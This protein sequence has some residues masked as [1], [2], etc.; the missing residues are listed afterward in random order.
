MQGGG[1]I[2]AALDVAGAPITVEEC[3]CDADAG[4][5]TA[6]DDVVCLD[7]GSADISASVA[8]SP[9]VPSGYAVYYVLTDADN[10]LTVVNASPSSTFTVGASGNYIIHTLVYDPNTLDPASA[11]GLEAA[12]VNSLLVQGGGT[13]CAALDLVG[14]PITVEGPDAGSLIA[15]AS[16]V[17]LVGGSATISATENAA[18][19]VPAGYQVLYVLTDADNNLEIL[20]AGATPQFTVSEEGN[21]IIHTLVYDP[22]TLD[23]STAIGLPAGAV[24]GLLVQGGGSICAALDLAGAPISVS[25]CTGIRELTAESLQVYPNPSQGDFVIELSGVDAED[26]QIL[27][28]DMTGRE[29]HSETVTVVD[30]FRKEMNLAVAKGTY[31]LQIIS[32]EF[33]ISRKLQVN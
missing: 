22:N 17:C 3:G 20:D 28:L 5:L 13:I 25:L 11:L 27:V 29:I 6:D 26:T 21:Y 32:N 4:T 14:A 24:N 7:G 31:I 12:V 10:N 8:T 30:G 9:T 15:D 23:P 18:P 33:V 19:E 2:C 16:L 1:S